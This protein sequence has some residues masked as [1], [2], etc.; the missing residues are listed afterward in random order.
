MNISIAMFNIAYNIMFLK[1]DWETSTLQTAPRA[2]GSQSRFHVLE[3][4][5]LNTD[6]F[7][8]KIHLSG[9]LTYY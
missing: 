8:L 2:A 1:Q 7:F 6:F 4:F 9:K 3:L 5:F